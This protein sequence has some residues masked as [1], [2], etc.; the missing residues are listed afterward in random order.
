MKSDRPLL[1]HLWVHT[2]FYPPVPDPLSVPWSQYRSHWRFSQ[3]FRSGYPYGNPECFPAYRSFR[4]YAPVLCHSSLQLCSHRQQ[5]SV[6]VPDLSYLRHRLCC[7]CLLL[8]LQYR[9][10]PAYHRNAPWKESAARFLPL[11][12]PENKLPSSWQTS[13]NPEYLPLYSLLPYKRSLP[14]KAH[15]RFSFSWSD[16][17]FSYAFPPFPFHT[18][19]HLF[20]LL[21]QQ[22]HDIRSCRRF[23]HLDHKNH[24]A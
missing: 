21:I 20:R 2:A 24:P 17:T 7:V 3:I 16:H 9:T 1:S 10:D 12:C 14:V 15:R 4:P 23:T 18:F 8:R 22:T 13:G 6:S 19:P 11:S 5:P